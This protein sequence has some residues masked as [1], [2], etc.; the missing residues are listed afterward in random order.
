LALLGS[1]ETD[2]RIAD[3]HRFHA[4]RAHL[5]E[6]ADDRDAARAA[7]TEAARRAPSLPQQRYLIRRR[8]NLLSHNGLWY[9]R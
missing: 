6:L 9:L 7:Y 4:A 3:G 8:D 5:L 1:L 2:Q